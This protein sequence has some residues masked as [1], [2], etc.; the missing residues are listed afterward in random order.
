MCI[1]SDLVTGVFPV[2][3]YPKLPMKEIMLLIGNDVPGG[4]VVPNL[5]IFDIPTA[6]MSLDPSNI[7]TKLFPVCAQTRVQHS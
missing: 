4:R 6:T 3:V 2:A 1:Q 5:D 7:D